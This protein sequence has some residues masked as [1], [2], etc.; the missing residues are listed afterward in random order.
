MDAI[1]IEYNYLMEELV[2]ATRKDV[3]F[4]SLVDGRVKKIYGAV[5]ENYDDEITVFRT[6]E[7]NK[8]FLIGDHRG[9]MTIWLYGNGERVRR[10]VPH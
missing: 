8:K 10:L 4:Y 6:V 2:V 9:N 1:N 7:Q 3:R 5:I